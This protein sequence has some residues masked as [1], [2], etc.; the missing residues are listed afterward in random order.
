MSMALIEALLLQVQA[1]AVAEARWFRHKLS[2]ASTSELVDLAGPLPAPGDM[3]VAL[4]V[5]RF[6]GAGDYFIPVTLD[7]GERDMP[8]R[9]LAAAGDDSGARLIDAAAEPA[10][11][12]A[13]LALIESD[14]HMQARHGRFEF[15][16]VGRVGR[17]GG[18]PRWAVR[19]VDG[20]YTNSIVIAE[21][22]VALK[23]FR[24]LAMGISPDVEVGA[25]LARYTDFDETACVLGEARYVTSNGAVYSTA[26]L[27]EAVPNVGDVWDVFGPALDQLA[28]CDTPSGRDVCS[29][30]AIRRLGATIGRL[31]LALAS[32]H[33]PGFGR[34]PL[35]PAV[36]DQWRDRVLGRAISAAGSLQEALD[37]PGHLADDAATLARQAIEAVPRLRSR[38]TR[39]GALGDLGEVIRCHGDLH[40]GQILLR[41]DGGFAVIDFEGEPLT[42]LGERSAPS[43]PAK[44]VAGMLRSFSYAS[45]SAQKRIAAQERVCARAGQAQEALA[46]W[47]RGAR[48]A[49]LDGY[50]G[51]ALKQGSNLWPESPETRQS[52]ISL[53]EMEKAFYEVVYEINNRPDWAAIP[54]AGIL[55]I[56]NREEGD[57]V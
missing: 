47:E 10:Y 8:G 19:R 15:R 13:V 35:I 1:Q 16:K 39:D 36:L 42:P 31:H 12:D 2:G 23:T 49:F 33:I 27:T 30:D 4:A 51:E 57:H 29:A 20:E 48:Q 14:A 38:L 34:S 22:S 21:R 5:V 25:A 26:V 7:S 45:H 46:K 9:I 53:F 54:L 55:R 24:M 52:L 56:L 50:F 32:I 18:R 43:S 11:A 17:V 3:P 28:C 37:R 44:D 6:T 40:L 41:P